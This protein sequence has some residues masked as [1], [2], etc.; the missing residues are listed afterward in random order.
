[1]KITIAGAGIAGLTAALV[2]GRRGHKVVV[3]ERNPAINPVGAGIVLA[4]N[5]L[6]I[7]TALGV[8]LQACG[9]PIRQ[10]SLRDACGAALETTE[11]DRILPSAGPTLA[12]H[13]A[14]LHRALL[15]ALHPSV[16]VRL[17]VP[18]ADCADVDGDLLIGADGIR[19]R[20]REQTCGPMPLRYSGTTCWRGIAP[21]PGVT[22]TFES[23]SGAARVGAVPLTDNRLY[24]YLVLTAPAGTPRQISI[25]AIRQSFAH[26][27]GPVPAILDS[28]SG[29]E[30]LH[31]DL[32][33]LHSPVWGSGKVLLIGDA[34]HAMTP[35]L[36]QGAAMGIEDAAVLP[37]VLGAS[38][39]AQRLHALR[40]QRVW[41]V[42]RDSRR[43]GEL[44]HWD[45]RGAVWLRNALV[46]RIPRSLADSNYRSV[47][48]P[49]LAFDPNL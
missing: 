18:L 25:D 14:E 20:V 42:Q 17:G 48:E 2:L 26:L 4:P 19:S 9:Q 8:Q 5:A 29:V 24:V 44:A 46:R 35:N 47:V 40:H 12:F 16:E 28:F 37:Q 30:L 1:M 38:D 36:G 45:S 39:P 10:I 27:A 21:N 32:E 11:I 7:L 6:R 31:H 15:N 33:E 43:I 49:G 23:W 13:R 41:R 22:E 3:L 34:A